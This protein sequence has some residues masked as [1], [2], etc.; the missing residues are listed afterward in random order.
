MMPNS[1]YAI[2]KLGAHHA[3]RMYRDGYGLHGS[4]SIC[5]NHESPRR[6]EHFV[7]RKITIYV[8]K[9]K[10][11]LSQHAALPCLSDEQNI[12]V[13]GTKYPKLRLGN[14]DACRD[15]S[16]AKDMVRGMWMMLQQE[17]PDDYVLASGETHSVRD[18]VRL[19]F[20]YIGIENWESYV[21]IDKGLYRPVEVPYLLGIADK[22]YLAFGWKPEYSFNDLVSDMMES[23]LDIYCN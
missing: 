7:T 11:M 8:A 3:V 16:H 18:F 19:C 23:D 13:N 14:I 22:A 10:Y 15:W 20:D 4:C 1:P 9:L 12:Y 6:G 5:F 2:A 17:K 21:Y